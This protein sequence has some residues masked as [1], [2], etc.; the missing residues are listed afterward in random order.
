M[1]NWGPMDAKGVQ[2]KICFEKGLRFTGGRLKK[3]GCSLGDYLVSS[4]SFLLFGQ[5]GLYSVSLELLILH[6]SR[7]LEEQD[8]KWQC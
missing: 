3:Y 7:S 5:L 2:G 8:S 4:E 1:V 6:L